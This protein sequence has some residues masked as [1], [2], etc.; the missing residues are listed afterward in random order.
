MFPFATTV[1]PLTKSA[2]IR[3]EVPKIADPAPSLENKE[4]SVD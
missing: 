3:I 2:P 4:V 1:V